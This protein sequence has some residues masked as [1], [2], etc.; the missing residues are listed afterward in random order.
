MISTNK[1]YIESSKGVK[2]E[3]CTLYDL[4]NTYSS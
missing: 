4:S 1:L 3:N 2:N